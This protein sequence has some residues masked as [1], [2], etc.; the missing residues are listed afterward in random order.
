MVTASFSEDYYAVLGVNPDST[1][2]RIKEAYRDLVFIVH[3]DRLPAERAR[4]RLVAEGHLRKINHAYEVLSDPSTRATYDSRRASL[5][6]SG[7]Q[8][9]E[10]PSERQPGSSCTADGIRRSEATRPSRDWI[11]TAAKIMMLIFVIVAIL[12]V[13]AVVILAVLS[14]VLVVGLI[15]LILAFCASLTRS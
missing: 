6:R 3:P 15:V 2:E 9:S 14:L 1:H 11:S 12:V 13:A 10:P 8:R 4:A 7:R 5:D